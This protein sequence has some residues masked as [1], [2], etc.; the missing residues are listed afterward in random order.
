M[1]RGQQVE[2]IVG[3]LI[4]V[5]AM[6]NGWSAYVFGGDVAF[7]VFWTVATPFMFIALGVVLM[8]AVRVVDRLSIKVG[9]VSLAVYD[10]LVDRMMEPPDGDP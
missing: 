9:R 5:V 3:S 6:V 2:A 10:R 4:L 7:A 1:S 8:L